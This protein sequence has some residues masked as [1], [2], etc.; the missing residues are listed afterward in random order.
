MSVVCSSRWVAKLCRKVCSD[1]RLLI[2]ASGA[3][4]WQARLSWRVVIGCTGS[5]PG[6]SQPC[7]RAAFHHSRNRSSRSGDSMTLRSLRPLPCSTRMT[8]RLLSMSQDLE[9]DDF[10]G[11][12]A[13]AIGHAQRRLV[14]EPRCSIE[15][16]R[17]LLLAQH[18]R[19]LARLMNEMRVLDDGISLERDPEK[20]PQC[21]N[22]PIDGGCAAAARHH[23]QL[24]TP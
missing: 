15:Q 4:A 23:M 18:N 10:G 11:A 8:M 6:N 3:A 9:R 1:T 24:K 13:R 14:L 16:P 19:Q 5:R 12:Q 17:H 7:G 20:E 2:S 21:R 22:V